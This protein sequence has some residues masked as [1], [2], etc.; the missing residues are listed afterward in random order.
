MGVFNSWLRYK[1]NSITP[2]IFAHAFNNGL[3]YFVFILLRNTEIPDDPGK[4]EFWEPFFFLLFGVTLLF[5]GFVLIR[6]Q[7]ADMQIS[8]TATQLIE[9]ES[10]DSHANKA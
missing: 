2:S 10:G 9:S 6:K 5:V 7:L 8:E 4:I 1:A 3:V